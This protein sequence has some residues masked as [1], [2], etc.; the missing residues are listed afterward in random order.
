MAALTQVGW[1]KNL[2]DLL[3]NSVGAE[4]LVADLTAEQDLLLVLPDRGD[5]AWPQLQLVLLEDDRS[6]R[7]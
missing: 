6:L 3:Q 1:R 7:I 2:S 4:D 5:V